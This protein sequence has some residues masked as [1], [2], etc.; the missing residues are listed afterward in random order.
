VS[1]GTGCLGLIQQVLQVI[2]RDLQ[3]PSSLGL[4]AACGLDCVFEKL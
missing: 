4:V 3:T 1:I 2:R